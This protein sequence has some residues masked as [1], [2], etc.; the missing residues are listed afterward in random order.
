MSAFLTRSIRC[1]SLAAGLALIFG[2]LPAHADTDDGDAPV[3][4]HSSI[5][6]TLEALPRKPLAQ[7]LA[8]TIYQFR[9]AMQEVTPLAATDMFT[10]ALIESGQFRVLERA[11]IDANV[12]REKQ[13]NAAGQTAGTVAHTQLHGAQYIF[14]GT[15]SEANGGQRANQGGISIGGLSLG[16][17]RN[18]DSLAIDVRIIDAASGDVLDSIAVSKIIKS[19]SES[20]GGTAA[21]ASTVAS[22]M[23]KRANPLTPDVNYQGARKE[24]V[25]KALRSCIEAAVLELIKRLPGDSANGGS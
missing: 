4:E 6:R 19:S 23:G 2:A 10:T 18:K 17:G 9:S 21:F 14:E 15:I 25:D 7:R 22:M 24:G 8:V 3:V 5:S 20:V 12:M 11:Q 13:M 1:A 16:G